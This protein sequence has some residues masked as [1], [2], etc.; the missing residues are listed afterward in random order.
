MTP[1]TESFVPMDRPADSTAPA[2]FFADLPELGV[3]AFDGADAASFLQGQLSTDIAALGDGEAEWSSYNSPKGRMLGSLLLWRTSP[4]SFRAAVSADLA[5]S[6]RQ[7]LSRYVLR[8]SVR[9]ADLTATGTRFGTD[10]GARDAVGAL[11]GAVPA[12]GRAIVVDGCNVVALPD[13]RLLIHAPHADAEA[14]R[15]RLAQR[16][17]MAA[18]ERWHRLGIA[19]GVPMIVKATE[20]LFVPQTANWD[21]IGGVD[22]RKGC[23][24]GQ[25]IVARMQY[26]GR[27]KERLFRFH[28]DAAPPAPATRI[29]GVAFGEQPCGTVVNATPAAD[30]GSDLLAVVQRSALDAPP[31]HLH[32]P[33]GPVLSARAL[34]YEIPASASPERLQL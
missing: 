18:G 16:L 21:L 31:L 29:F 6:L 3:L 12:V 20:D 27:L 25:E 4:E 14:L 32:A 8:A 30:G 28:V 24:P 13:G 2:P 33:D 17:P 26:L 22:F 5:E 1:D 7:R 9:V 15:A 34:P 10:A 19:A 23:Y 11:L